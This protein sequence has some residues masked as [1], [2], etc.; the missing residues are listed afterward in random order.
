[1]SRRHATI[2]VDAET[3][4]FYIQDL[5]TANGTYVNNQRLGSESVPSVPLEVNSGDEISLACDVVA[6]GKVG[7]EGEMYWGV[8]ARVNWE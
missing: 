2:W 6:E 7:E 1:M 8:K 3:R 4:K 5:G